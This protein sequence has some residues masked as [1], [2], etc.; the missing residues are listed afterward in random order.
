MQKYINRTEKIIICGNMHFF[1]MIDISI[2]NCIVIYNSFN[3]YHNT[4]NLNLSLGFIKKLL[5]EILSYITSN[6][7]TNIRKEVK[8]KFIS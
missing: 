3:K 7:N 1:S 6:N 4:N 8:I 5:I 2:R